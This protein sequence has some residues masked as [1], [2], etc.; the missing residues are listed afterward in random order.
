[1]IAHPLLDKDMELWESI[2]GVNTRAVMPLIMPTLMMEADTVSETLDYTAIIIGLI[3]WEDFI[4]LETDESIHL[5]KIS[6][7]LFS[8]FQSVSMPAQD[9]QISTLSSS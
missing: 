9:N 6:K 5:L 7:S 8:V 1:M 4:G 3:T 2:T